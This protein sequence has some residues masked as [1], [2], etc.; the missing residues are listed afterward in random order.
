M[1]YYKIK[2]I[3]IKS[4]GKLSV[5]AADSSMS[6][7]T[8]FTSKY[9]GTVAEFLA[10]A[11]EGNFHLNKTKGNYEYARILEAIS[12]VMEMFDKAGITWEEAYTYKLMDIRRK[13]LQLVTEAYAKRILENDWSDPKKFGVSLGLELYPIVL[14]AVKELEAAQKRDRENG[15]I[16]ITCAAYSIFCDADGKDYDLLLERGT[17]EFLLAPNEDYKGGVLRT[18]PEKIIRMDTKTDDLYV[19]LSFS[20]TGY[21]LDELIERHPNAAKSKEIVMDKARRTQLVIKQVEARGLRLKDGV[22]PYKGY[23]QEVAA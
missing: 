21:T 6:P 1:S 4:N 18:K 9:D 12:G 23:R 15:I 20:G 16:R 13:G 2:R 3:S 19:W 7:A 5:C 22:E 11:Y 8:Y 14:E 10:S 17:E